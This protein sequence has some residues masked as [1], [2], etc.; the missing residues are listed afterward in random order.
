LCG[1]LLDEFQM[2]Y[3]GTLA[4]NRKGIPDELKKIGGRKEGDYVSLFEEGGK[5]SLHS[6]VCNT[7]SG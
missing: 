1:R 6:W 4:L 3:T 7:K 2:T 5:K